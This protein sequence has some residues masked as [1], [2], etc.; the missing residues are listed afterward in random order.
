MKEVFLAIERMLKYLIRIH[1]EKSIKTE[2]IDKD[3][4]KEILLIN[5]MIEIIEMR[6]MM[7]MIEVLKMIKIKD[8]ID[9]IEMIE[10]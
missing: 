2:I 4:Y 6:E 9:M 5:W 3:I 1:K 8:M 7:E 10:N